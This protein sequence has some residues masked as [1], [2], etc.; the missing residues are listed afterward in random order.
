MIG[1]RE[2]RTKA[3][4]QLAARWKEESPQ[5]EFELVTDGKVEYREGERSWMFSMPPSTYNM[6]RCGSL[7]EELK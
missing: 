5:V 3:E 6:A 1:H 7:K 4:V 2:R